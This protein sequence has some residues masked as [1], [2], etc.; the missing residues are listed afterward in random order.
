MPADFCTSRAIIFNMD[1]VSFTSVFCTSKLGF[2]CNSTQHLLFDC[3]CD[4]ATKKMLVFAQS[5]CGFCLS[6]DMLYFSSQRNYE[7]IFPLVD[8]SVELWS[9]LNLSS[10]IWP[11]QFLLTI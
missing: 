4:F 9:V 11:A 6:V 5:I 10:V 2:T 1:W 8:P 7:F 3:P